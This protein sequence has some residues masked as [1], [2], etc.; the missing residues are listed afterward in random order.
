MFLFGAKSKEAEIAT[1]K[2]VEGLEWLNTVL[3]KYEG[4]LNG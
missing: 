4:A 2:H 3:L 1:W